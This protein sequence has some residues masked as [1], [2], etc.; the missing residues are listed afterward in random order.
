MGFLAI[1]VWDLRVLGLRDLGDE[2]L[3]FRVSDFR[4]F[5]V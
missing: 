2:D 1:Q 5:R 4:G 3:G